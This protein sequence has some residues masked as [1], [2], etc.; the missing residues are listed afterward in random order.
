[1]PVQAPM[2]PNRLYWA[3]ALAGPNPQRLRLPIDNPRGLSGS[4]RL[5]DRRQFGQQSTR[6]VLFHISPLANVDSPKYET[7]TD[8]NPNRNPRLRLP[9]WEMIESND[10]EKMVTALVLANPMSQISS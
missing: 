9:L 6:N 4:R 10:Y 2:D 5:R 1:M 8:C 3:S 7:K